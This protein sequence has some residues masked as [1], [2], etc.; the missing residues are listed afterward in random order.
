MLKRASFDYAVI[1]V[2][3]RV[4]RQ[5]FINAG[6]IAYCPERRYLAAQTRLE[7]ARV[8]ALWP[9]ADV[10]LI[11]GHLAAVER[12]CGGDAHAG[13]IAL[14]SQRERFHWLTAPRSTILQ[15]SPVHTGVCDEMNGVLA[16]LV[17]QFLLPA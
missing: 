7:A 2:V 9:D 17:A 16:R 6:V 1:R 15:P 5:E 11:A 12:I 10:A 13:P 14:L 8:L 3:P 4:E